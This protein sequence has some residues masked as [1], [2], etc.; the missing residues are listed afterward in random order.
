MPRVS[1]SPIVSSDNTVLLMALR[2]RAG[3][4]GGGRDAAVPGRRPLGVPFRR[5]SAPDILVANRNSLEETV[6]WF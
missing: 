5:G 3:V 2:D 6:E 1:L 4:G